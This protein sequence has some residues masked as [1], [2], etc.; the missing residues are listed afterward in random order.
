[1]NETKTNEIFKFYPTHKKPIGLIS[2]PHSGEEIP[3]EFKEFIIDDFVILSRDVD[4]A[5]HQLIDIKELNEAGISVI[6]ANIHRIVIDLNRA[7]DQSMLNW[8]KNSHGENIVIKEPS[9]EIKHGFEIKYHA[10][11]YEMLKALLNELSKTMNKASFVDLH[12]MPSKATDYHLKITPNQDKIRPDFCLSDVMGESCDENFIQEFKS[13]FDQFYKNVN[14][15][16]PYFGGNV[17]RE[18]NKIFPHINNI[19]IEI[20]RAL[21]LDE[22]SRSI[23]DEKANILK[24]NLTNILIKSF[25]NLA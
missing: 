2:I 14:I 12:S 20:S 25:Q 24:E 1:M 5:V 10:P 16:N 11:Y 6:K 8:K 13:Q 17:T 18:I 23:I 3:D 22:M 21:Y 7:Q 19:Q 4:T 9:A 15:N